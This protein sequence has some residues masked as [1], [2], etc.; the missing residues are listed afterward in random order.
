MFHLIIV[1][2][3]DDG[4]KCVWREI[5]F[6]DPRTFRDLTLNFVFGRLWFV[7]AQNFSITNLDRRRSRDDGE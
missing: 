7:C 5:N 1:I 4:L 3:R 2:A 6:C